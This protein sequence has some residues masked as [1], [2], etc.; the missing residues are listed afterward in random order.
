MLC[1]SQVILPP[2]G[3][4]DVMVQIK[5]CALSRIDT[6][7]I[8]EINVNVEQVPVGCEISG[9][10]SK[11][12]DAVSLSVGDEVAGLLPLDSEC[13]GCAEYCVLPEYCLV[14]KPNTVSFA[15]SAASLRGGLMAYT[16]LHH[17][18][19]LE[20]GAIVLV[21]SALE[22][23][24]MIILQLCELLGA[25]VIAA[26]KSPDEAAVAKKLYPSLL[27]VIDMSS[28]QNLM[29]VCLQETGGLGVDCIIDDGVI[30]SYQ[31]TDFLIEPAP[32]RKQLE[33]ETCRYEYEVVM[34]TSPTNA[35]PSFPTKHQLISCLAARGQWVTTQPRLQLDPPESQLL[36]MKGASLH[37]LFEPVW[38]LSGAHQGHYL[39]TMKTI[40]ARLDDKTLKP[41]VFKTVR[42]EQVCE[43]LV[44]LGSYGIGKVVMKPGEALSCS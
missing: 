27:C 40:M 7:T 9:V 5:A 37:F 10:V 23:E 18:T 42:L 41:Y 44:R 26:V 38:G 6:K 13:P 1:H 29:E 22:G 20:P 4:Y 12:G 24:R 3:E 11:V 8:R 28:T 15:D 25:K 34:P 31:L 35:P 36:L 33:Q 21:C 32:L 43:E 30:P 16:A 17:Q 39:Q 19:R 2:L 14:L